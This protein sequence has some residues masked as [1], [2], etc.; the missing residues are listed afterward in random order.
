M[1]IIDYYLQTFISISFQVFVAEGGPNYEDDN[2]KLTRQMAIF[3]Y[4]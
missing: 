2:C 4:F 1:V 3:M